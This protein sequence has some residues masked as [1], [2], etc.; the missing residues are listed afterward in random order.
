AE[1]DT[2]LVTAAAHRLVSG[3]FLVEER[4]AHALKGVP[5]PVTLYRVVQPSGV[6][7][8]LAAAAVL[9]LT[10]FIGREDERPLLRTRFEQA[11]E[12]ARRRPLATLA[13]WV[14]GAARLQP[15]VILLEDLHWVDPSTLELQQLLVEQG[16]T[17]Q[18]LLLYTARGDFQAPWPLRAH[19]TQLMLSRLP[20]R[21]LREMVARVA[22]RTALPEAVVK[23]S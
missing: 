16:A 18:L 20:R 23:R 9:G 13:A 1:P 17:A 11:P 5:A 2:V 19:H 12:V 22:A 7:S 8:R 14:L 10:P 15:L 21:H 3:L 4:G 6:R